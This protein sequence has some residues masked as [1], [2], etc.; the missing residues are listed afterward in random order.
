LNSRAG[1]DGL[2]QVEASALGE[3]LAADDLEAG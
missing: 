1:Q 3:K 2:D